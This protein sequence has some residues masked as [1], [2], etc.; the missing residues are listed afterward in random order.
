M[1]Y[2][3]RGVSEQ[4]VCGLRDGSVKVVNGETELVVM[5]SGMGCTELWQQPREL[6]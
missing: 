6:G 4:D 5:D 2:W 1:S 3:V